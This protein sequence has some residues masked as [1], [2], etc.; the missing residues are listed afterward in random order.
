MTANFIFFIILHVFYGK[1][2]DCIQMVDLKGQHD[3]I[4]DEID[5]AVLE[6]MASGSYIQ[7]PAVEEFELGL[8][9][10]VGSR[11]VVSCASGTDA[12][13]AAL[14]AAGITAG[15]E[16]ITTPFTFFATA[17]AV[18]RVGAKPVFVDICEDTFNINPNLIE[19]KI[20]RRTKAVIPV[21][22]FG[23]CAD[24]EPILAIAARHNLVVIE[25][26]CQA[27]G[28]EYTFSDGTVRQAG[29]MGLLGCT[30]FFPTKNLGCCGDGGA[31]MTNDQ[32]L[33]EKV[34]MICHHGSK[35][36]YFHEM[37]GMN[38]RL[39][40]VQAAVLNVKLKHFDEYISARRRAAGHYLKDL[41][42]CAGVQLPVLSEKSTHTFHQF[43]VKVDAGMRDSFR[44]LLKR[45]GIPTTVYYPLP[46]H[47]Q[48]CF[49]PEHGTGSF[50][51]S[52][53]VCREVV[54]LPMHT[55]LD[56]QQ[57]LYICQTIV[58]S[59]L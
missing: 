26:A 3:R 31:V 10:Y 20:T 41:A 37:F 40:T 56:D 5:A 16:V 33:A 28:A 44:E 46:V 34:R 13:T 49:S 12:L 4:R 7:G 2:M 35:E 19:E 23:Q 1:E 14:M 51:C 27:L 17:G 36:K 47:L 18:V 15:D 57:L 50:P 53:R 11:H 32:N 38:S 55:E 52:E 59:Q 48:R 43:T 45:N 29:T 25:D 39:D 54:S 24:M 22:L 8:A 42:G 9:R 21:H 30:S 6:V 58:S